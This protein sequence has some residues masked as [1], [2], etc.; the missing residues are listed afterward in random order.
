MNE[1]EFILYLMEEYKGALLA[2]KAEEEWE[3]QEDERVEK[4]RE[5][6][7]EEKTAWI[8]RNWYSGRHVSKAELNRIR[9]MLHKAM[10]AVE[11]EKK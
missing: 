8:S 11:E 9:L 2:I 5:E 6:R 3:R 1:K 7:G 4:L 10:L